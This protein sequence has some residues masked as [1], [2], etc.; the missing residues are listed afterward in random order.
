MPVL[1]DDT[2][3]TEAQEEDMPTE[4]VDINRG[5]IVVVPIEPVEVSVP[6]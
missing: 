3:P 6:H 2:V 4:V 1:E 5:K